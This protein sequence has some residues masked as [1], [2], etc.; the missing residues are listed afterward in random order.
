M[1]EV[2]NRSDS[3]PGITGKWRRTSGERRSLLVRAVCSL[4]GASISLTLSPFRRAIAFGCVPLAKERGHGALA[5]YVWAIQAAARRVPWRALCIEQGLAL[6]RLMRRDGIDARLHY[7]VR[8]DHVGGMLQAHVWV[9][10]DG[11]AVIGG[12]ETGFA[13]VA[14]Y[15]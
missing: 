11:M 7:G 8:H 4:A 5:D 14:T 6:Q 10:V 3:R 1:G 12:G 9:T 13:E 2:F 15:P